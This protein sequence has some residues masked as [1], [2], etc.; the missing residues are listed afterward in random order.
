MNDYSGST[1]QIIKF[2][3]LLG[4]E[5]LPVQVD[6][7]AW[8][9]PPGMIRIIHKNRMQM[10]CRNRVSARFVGMLFCGL[11]KRPST[12]N[13]LGHAMALA[14]SH[15]PFTLEAQVQSLACQCGICGRQ[16][17]IG[18]GFSEYCYFP[19]SVPFHSIPYSCLYSLPYHQCSIISTVDSI[20]K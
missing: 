19:L 1:L 12:C 3:P 4:D 16:N 9:Q 8:V 20:H 18:T 6:G 14:F 7:E 10:L 2:I 13:K 5:G 17:G 11:Y 15:W